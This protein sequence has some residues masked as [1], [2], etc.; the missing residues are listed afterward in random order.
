VVSAFA[1]THFGSRE[2]VVR[3]PDGRLWNLQA[4]GQSEVSEK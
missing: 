3:D 1:D 4:P 2:A